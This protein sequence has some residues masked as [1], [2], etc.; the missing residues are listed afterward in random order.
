MGAG[1][2]VR[3]REAQTGSPRPEVLV[4]G[5]KVVEDVGRAEHV[6]PLSTIVRIFYLSMLGS[7]MAL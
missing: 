1:Q 4:A 7:I 2:P 3:A 5:G 6:W